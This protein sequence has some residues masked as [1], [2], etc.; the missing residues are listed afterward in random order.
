MINNLYLCQLDYVKIVFNRIKEQSNNENFKK[1]LEYFENTFIEKYNV[2][3][4]KYFNNFRHITNNIS[5]Y[6][7][8]K[9]IFYLNKNLLILSL[10]TNYD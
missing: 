4:W 8:A 7:N 5:E 2:K 9:L 1:F 10:Y 3:C 6:Y